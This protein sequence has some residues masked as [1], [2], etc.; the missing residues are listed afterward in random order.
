MKLNCQRDNVQSEKQQSLPEVQPS[1]S[2]RPLDEAL[3]SWLSHCHMNALMFL[4]F[5]VIEDSGSVPACSPRT[6]N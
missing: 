1:P 3:E 5:I 6:N 2:P 4:Y